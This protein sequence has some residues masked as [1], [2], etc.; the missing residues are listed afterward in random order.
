MSQ[1]KRYGG[2]SR[3]GKEKSG[4]LY[5]FYRLYSGNGDFDFN[6]AIRTIVQTVEK[7]DVELGGAI[8]ADS[9]PDLEYQET[10]HK[11][12]SIFVLWA[13]C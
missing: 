1:A 7:I 5:R 4:H 8:I 13:L 2:Y 6:I 9:D 11:G 3:F 10:L 12:S